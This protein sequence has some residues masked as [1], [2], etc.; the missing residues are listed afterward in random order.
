MARLEEYFHPILCM[1][2]KMTKGVSAREMRSPSSVFFLPTMRQGIETEG[3]LNSSWTLCRHLIYVPLKE[4]SAEYVNKIKYFN[5][6]SYLTKN[7]IL[8][9]LYLTLLNKINS[10]IIFQKS[11]VQVLEISFQSLCLRLSCK[12][13]W[14]AEWPFSA[15][16]GASRSCKRIC[17]WCERSKIWMMYGCSR[18]FMKWKRLFRP[19]AEE[20]SYS[21]KS[22]SHVFLFLLILY[23]VGIIFFFN[24]TQFN[25]PLKK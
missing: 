20:S 18:L 4:I 24:S 23:A 10:E 12:V 14:G 17:W 25:I 9:I 15:A 8:V 11:K 1:L 2:Y 5:I 13:W 19:T 7:K 16:Q 6:F 3:K 21:T 22:L